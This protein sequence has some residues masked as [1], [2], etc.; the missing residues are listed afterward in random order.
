MVELTAARATLE[1]RIA[2]H[3]RLGTGKLTDPTLFASLLDQ[4]VF[5]MAGQPRPD[6]VVD[7]DRLSPDSAAGRIA[8]ALTT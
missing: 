4:G 7:T 5:D 6:L 1:S 3:S 2:S 8:D